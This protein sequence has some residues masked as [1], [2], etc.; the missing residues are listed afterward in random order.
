MWVTNGASIT[1]I[2]AKNDGTGISG[3]WR[4]VIAT[5]QQ[6]LIVYFVPDQIGTFG[7][8][9]YFASIIALQGS[10]WVNLA[11]L[12]YHASTGVWQQFILP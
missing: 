7:N 1:S 2:T 10:T 4:G 3:Y 8:D 6:D 11:F 5:A 9:Y 12:V